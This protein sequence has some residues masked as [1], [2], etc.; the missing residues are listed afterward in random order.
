M[1]IIIAKESESRKAGCP[2]TNKAYTCKPISE[3]E[4]VN[5]QSRELQSSGRTVQDEAAGQEF[6]ELVGTQC[7]ACD[8]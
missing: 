8:S 4:I 6:L 2:I 1:F 7:V 3:H 5:Q